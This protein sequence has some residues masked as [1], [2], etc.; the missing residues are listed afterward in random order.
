MN[1]KFDALYRK[2][3]KYVYNVALGILRNKTDAEDITQDVFIK[4]FNSIN[5]F[6]GESDIKTYLYRMTINKSIDLIR[7]YNLHNDKLKEIQIKRNNTFL[8]IELYNLLESLD[9]KHK[10]PLL[11]A[12]IGGFSYKEISEILNINIGTVKSRINRAIVKLKNKLKGGQ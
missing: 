6:R 10:T 3:S 2:Y 11:L 5:S 9:L 7:S 12:E 8:K 1:L 4:F